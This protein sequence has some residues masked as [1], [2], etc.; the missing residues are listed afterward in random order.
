MPPHCMH[1]VAMPYSVC[2]SNKFENTLIACMHTPKCQDRQTQP[3]SWQFILVCPLPTRTRACSGHAGHLCP[4][5]TGPTC[6]R[7]ELARVRAGVGS[8]RLQPMHAMLLVGL[9]CLV[10]I[11]RGLLL[12]RRPRQLFARRLRLYGNSLHPTP[13]MLTA[14]LHLMHL[15]HRPV[16]HPPHSTPLMHVAGPYLS[17][18]P[19]IAYQA[20]HVIQHHVSDD[21]LHS[22]YIWHRTTPS[23]TSSVQSSACVSNDVKGTT[24]M[25]LST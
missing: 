15:I 19:G 6:T 18:I 17:G 3:G 9:S 20:Q 8:I 14:S 4:Q 10:R 12:Q 25:H 24:V 13:P 16:L 11:L 5:V 1:H 2:R 7:F 22:A 21:A 23:V